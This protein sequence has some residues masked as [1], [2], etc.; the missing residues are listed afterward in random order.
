MKTL[1]IAA[2]AAFAP[3]AHAGGTAEAI[4]ELVKVSAINANVDP[5]LALAVVEQES[6]FVPDKEREEKK[7][8]TYSVGLFQMFIPTARAMGFKGTKEQLKNP[9]VNIRL[10]IEHLKKCTARFGSDLRLVACCHNAGPAVKVSFCSS[11]AWT[12]N[13]VKE[14]MEKRAKWDGILHPRAR[15]LAC[16]L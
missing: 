9:V 12:A 3:A 5:A 14:V 15:A 8:K 10:G 13:Y 1:L 4:K 16:A 11:Y 2:M 6:S 7:Y